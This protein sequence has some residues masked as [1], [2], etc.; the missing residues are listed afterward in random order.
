MGFLTWLNPIAGII[1]VIGK[2]LTKS[3][4]VDLEKYKVDGQVDIVAMQTDTAIIKARADLIKAMKDDPATK[5]GRWFFIVPTGIYFTLIIYDSCFRDVFPDQT[6][7]ILA[8]PDHI[9]Y[10]PY[11]VVAYLF[12][13]AFNR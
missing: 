9:Q 2:F 11:A 6:W 4:D 5:A 8:L 10:I 13:L 12:A 3:Q 7:R 1:N